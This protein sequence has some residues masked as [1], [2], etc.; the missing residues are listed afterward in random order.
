MKRLFL[1]GAI[2]LFAFCT[3]FA[4]IRG[5]NLTSLRAAALATA[6]TTFAG[7]Q[8]AE[9]LQGSAVEQAARPVVV[10][11]YT[12]Q[13]C[14][15]CPPADKLLGELAEV[16]NVL[17]LSFHVDYWDY[18][19]WPDEYALPG[20]TDRQRDH[21]RNLRQKFVY[22]P[23]LVVDGVEHV[24]GSRRGEVLELIDAAA[25]DQGEEIAVN[26]QVEGDK[27]HLSAP[28]APKSEAVVW[29]AFFDDEKSA[30]IKRGENAG[31]Q[32]NYHNVVRDFRKVG[33]WDGGAADFTLDLSDAHTHDGCAIIVQ[34]AD[35]GRIIGALKMDL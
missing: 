21:A 5:P 10:E 18:I 26:I 17:A 35:D 7:V 28:S 4:V 27:L 2:A 1:C 11:L 13:G 19:G 33:T 8:V 9:L 34:Q 24:V 6:E 3:V 16:P 12:S 29:M 23:Q 22:T 30:D 32:L 14:H 15:S 31:K 20:N 25:R